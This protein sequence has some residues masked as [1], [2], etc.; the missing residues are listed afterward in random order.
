MFIIVNCAVAL[1]ELLMR[2]ITIFIISNFEFLTNYALKFVLL[3]K[4]G[5]L[6]IKLYDEINKASIVK[7]K[8]FKDGYLLKNGKHKI[9][10]CSVY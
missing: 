7:T 3:K 2:M 5:K 10:F 6:Y 8:I 9:P 1:Q 4:T